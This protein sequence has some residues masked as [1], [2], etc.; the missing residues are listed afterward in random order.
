MEQSLAGF[1]WRLL[2]PWASTLWWTEGGRKLLEAGCG[3]G[4]GVGMGRGG[5]LR[6]GGVPQPQCLPETITTTTGM[7]G[8]AAYLTR[9]QIF[10]SFRISSA[11][12]KTNFHTVGSLQ[13]YH[14]EWLLRKPSLP[15]TVCSESQMCWCVICIGYNTYNTIQASCSSLSVYNLL[16]KKV[17]ES[18]SMQHFF[19]WMTK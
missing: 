6:L 16:I 11:P 3:K 7:M 8:R 1:S 4:G 17:N 10:I 2:A 13:D 18:C 19:K 12:K 14:G 5:W 9:W 15:K